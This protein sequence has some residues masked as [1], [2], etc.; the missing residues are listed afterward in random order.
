MKRSANI[1]VVIMSIVAISLTSCSKDNVFGDEE[2]WVKQTDTTTNTPTPDDPETDG[3][4][5]SCIVESSFGYD[6]NTGK[7]P[8]RL[9]FHCTDGRDTTFLAYCPMTSTI[10]AP[11]EK[12]VEPATPATRYLNTDPKVSL[13]STNWYRESDGYYYRTITRTQVVHMNNYDATVTSTHVEAKMIVNGK[14]ILFLHGNEGAPT[15]VSD[16]NVDGGEKER[17]GKTYT[18]EV[19]NLR[20]DHLLHGLYHENLSSSTNILREKVEED[21]MP[22]PDLKVS[23]F[24]LVNNIT[25][26]PEFQGNSVIWH[27]VCLTRNTIN[28]TE[29][30][31]IWVDGS[32]KRTVEL[33]SG[34]SNE[35]YNSAYLADGTWV[36]A[37]LKYSSANDGGWDYTFVSGGNAK[38]KTI[39]QNMALTSGLSNFKKD[40]NASQTPSVLTTTSTKEYNGK[41]LVTVTGFDKDN[42]PVITFTIGEC[43]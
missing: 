12:I 33:N 8:S 40:N 31:S 16:G 4:D 32:F 11:A 2:D 15:L 38:I 17:Y 42:R 43:L 27:R 41:K 23:S 14:E 34:E 20:M 13:D 21:E 37:I 28:G 1:W 35:K 9:T 25:F 22:N 24:G 6:I 26:S 36:P 3:I 29:Y 19:S 5:W 7:W 10:T 30:F 18:I 39:D